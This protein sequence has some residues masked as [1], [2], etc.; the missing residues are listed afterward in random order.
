MPPVPL[1]LPLPAPGPCPSRSSGRF[2][3]T[4]PARAHLL[5]WLDTSK[6]RS[7]RYRPLFRQ[8]FVLFILDC[9]LLG[10]LGAKPAEGI[11]IILARI[12]TVYY[13]AH[14]LVILPILGLV[15]KPKE[16]PESI[17]A[18]VLPA[19]PQAAE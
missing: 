10:Y 9:L 15:E 18:S 8:F 16:V 7:A 19:S 4:R 5:P 11:Y 3:W 14:F 1:P 6:V 12:G 2:Q 13:F 17:S